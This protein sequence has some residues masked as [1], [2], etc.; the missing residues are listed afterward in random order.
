MYQST[1]AD[2]L[3]NYQAAAELVYVYTSEHIWIHIDTVDAY[4][5]ISI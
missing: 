3:I 2:Q 4:T 1:N 5:I